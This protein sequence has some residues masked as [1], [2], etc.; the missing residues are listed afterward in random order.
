MISPVV[1]PQMQ[2]GEAHPTT[3]AAAAAA[4]AV[5]AEP[6]GR[7]STATAFGMLADM[8]APACPKAARLWPPEFT[9]AAAGALAAC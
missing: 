6:V 2:A 8:A 3:Q 9:W 4:T 1:H 5:L 7:P